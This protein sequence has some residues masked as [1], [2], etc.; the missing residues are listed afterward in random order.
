MPLRSKLFVDDQALEAAFVSNPAH[1]TRGAQ[2][3]YA[4]KIQQCVLIHE[5]A[6]DLGNEVQTRTYGPQTAA[7][8]QKYK[9]N[10][11]IINPAYQQAADDIVGIMTMQRMDKDMLDHEGQTG[12]EYIDFTAAEMFRI[13]GDV[14]R[15]RHMLNIVLSRLRALAAVTPGRGL[16]VTPRNLTYYDT[17]LKVF[18]IFHINTFTADDFPVNV[19]IF[20]SLAALYRGQPFPP[21][22]DPSADG[23]LF[24]QLLAN[25]I[26]VQQGMQSH[27][28]KQFWPSATYRGNPINFFA[29][30]VGSSRDPDKAV[31]FTR[32]Y[33]NVDEV[34]DDSRA[35]L[36]R[37]APGRSQRDHAG[38]GTRQRLL[39]RVA[40]LCVAA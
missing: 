6:I 10:R 29:A 39:L 18:R 30:F 19:E 35:V 13:D 26:T 17:K 20:A 2:G 15:S 7:A 4:A 28:A 37:A 34:D 27:F 21:P 25:F 36:R 8:V 12:P 24:S 38:A 22:G 11:K 3:D 31:H 14:F 1:I 23:V 32:R 33:F 5:T 16:L 9:A 40:D